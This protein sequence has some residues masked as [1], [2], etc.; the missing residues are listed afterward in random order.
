MIGAFHAFWHL[1]L[2]W[3]VG[4]NQIK[5]G[6]GIGFFF[7]IAFVIASSIFTTW[8]YIRNGSSTLAATLLH[9]T[10]NLNFD[11]FATAPESMKH[12]IYII[13]MVLGALMVILTWRNRQDETDHYSNSFR[14]K[15]A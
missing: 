13:L 2:F 3:V 14:A 7:F 5:M 1:P 8:C 4:T 6:F 15:G 9:C 11:I 10:G 12:R